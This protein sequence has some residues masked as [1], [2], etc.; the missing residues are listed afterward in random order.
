MYIRTLNQ[1][2]YLFLTAA[3][4]VVITIVSGIPN[5]QIKNAMGI[6]E[7]DKLGHIVIFAILAY[8]L[9][10]SLD[11]TIKSWK[12]ATQ[13]LLVLILTTLFGCFDELHQSTVAGRSCSLSDLLAD[14]IGGFIGAIACLF[15]RNWLPEICS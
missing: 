9:T 11:K 15:H 14:G 7:I 3:W 10:G 8:L 13:I 12:L 6:P 4:A 1:R 5:L 2:H